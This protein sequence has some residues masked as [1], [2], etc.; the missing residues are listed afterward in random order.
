MSDF[1]CTV[2][3]QWF[4]MVR[5]YLKLNVAKWEL[6]TYKYGKWPYNVQDDVSKL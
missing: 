3:P 2:Q 1:N 4:S 5:A 6:I